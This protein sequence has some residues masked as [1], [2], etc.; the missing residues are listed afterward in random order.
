EARGELVVALLVVLGDHAVERG[1][2]RVELAVVRVDGLVRL[3]EAQRD[4]ATLE[5]D[6]DDLDEDVLADRHDLLRELDVLVRQLRD[7]HEALDAVRHAHECA[8]RDELGD[9]ARRDLADRV[10][11]GEDLPRVLLG[12]LEGERHALALEVDIEDL[13]GDLLADLDDLA[14]VLDVLP[15]ELGDVHETVDTAEVDERAEVD[16]RG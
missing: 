4:A 14:R 16:D 5:V 7:V 12:R 11:A 15:R 1:E 10:G 8:E 3:L 9:L 13:D 2:A 6:V